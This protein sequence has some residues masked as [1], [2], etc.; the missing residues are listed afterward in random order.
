MSRSHQEAKEL[1]LPYCLYCWGSPQRL[2]TPCLW[3]CSQP[4][5]QK[6]KM[7]FFPL[8]PLCGNPVMWHCRALDESHRAGCSQD[9]PLLEQHRSSPGDTLQSTAHALAPHHITGIS[10]C[11]QKLSC[12]FQREQTLSHPLHVSGTPSDDVVS[13]W[14]PSWCPPLPH[15]A[16]PEGL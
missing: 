3:V 11:C 14:C 5:K 16:N 7:Y 15:P 13:P 1:P 6:A 4:H 2:Q 8:S 9:W 10:P 12:S